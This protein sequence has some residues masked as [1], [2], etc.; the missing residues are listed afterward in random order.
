MAHPTRSA[1]MKRWRIRV[2]ERQ[3][4]DGLVAV[5]FIVAADDKQAAMFRA[6]LLISRQHPTVSLTWVESVT[7]EP[8]VEL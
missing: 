6:G 2:V 1:A 3:C 7:E 4:S 5:E 8:E